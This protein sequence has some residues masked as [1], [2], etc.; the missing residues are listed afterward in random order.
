MADHGNEKRPDL[1]VEPASSRTAT[2]A[3]SGEEKNIIPEAQNRDEKAHSDF[4]A[5]NRTPNQNISPDEGE[6]DAESVDSKD[7]LR[8]SKARCIALV[9]TVTGASFLNVSL[10]N[11]RLT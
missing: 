8:L 5:D 7:E 11:N 2:L 1:A 6:G 4:G 10:P 9:C 3:V